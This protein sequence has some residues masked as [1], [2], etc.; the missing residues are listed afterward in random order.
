MN[1]EKT[2]RLHTR[3]RQDHRGPGAGRKDLDETV[4]CGQHGRPH[5]TAAAS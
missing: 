1:H 3:H 5:H 2:G 4:E